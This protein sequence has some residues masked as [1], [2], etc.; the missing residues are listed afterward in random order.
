MRLKMLYATI[1]LAGVLLASH[2]SAVAAEENTTAPAD[3]SA[4][5][6]IVVKEA[7]YNFAPVL[8]GMTVLHE[9]MIE[10]KGSA[11]LEIESVRPG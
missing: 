4:V 3:A 8:E 9:Y 5:P 6:V 2:F 11:E 10:N 1:T 7:V